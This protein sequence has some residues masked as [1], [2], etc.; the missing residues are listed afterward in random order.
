MYKKLNKWVMQGPLG[1]IDRH[2]D[3]KTN[4]GTNLTRKQCRDYLGD[5]GRHRYFK[6]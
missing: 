6:E 2:R 4:T 3:F 5:A 1:D